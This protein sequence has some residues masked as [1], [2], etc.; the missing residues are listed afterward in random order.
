MRLNSSAG[1][2]VFEPLAERIGYRN[3]MYVVCV[4]QSVALIGER[5][6]R[7]RHT[8]ILICSPT[9]RKLLAGLVSLA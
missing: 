8:P 2:F 1:T 7:V 5:D 9:H 4:I 3:S 6:T